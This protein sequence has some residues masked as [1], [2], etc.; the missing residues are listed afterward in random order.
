VSLPAQDNEGAAPTLGMSYTIDAS[1]TIVAVS[2][3]WDEFACNN[4]GKATVAKQVIGQKL[5][6]FIHGDDTLMF[7]RT[8]IMSAR[9]LQRAVVRPYRCDSPGIKRYMEMTVQ[10]HAMGMVEVTH[11]ELRCES[12]APKVRM[13]AAAPATGST[14][15]KRCSMCNRIRVQQHWSEVDEA[16]AAGQLAANDLSTLRVVYGVCPDCLAGREDGVF[17]RCAQ[18]PMP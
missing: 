11:R 12:M 9:T 17:N 1:D 16:L 18:K 6:R 10:P 14:V 8:M 13:I 3:A 4:E 2:G 15:I 7:V 5:D